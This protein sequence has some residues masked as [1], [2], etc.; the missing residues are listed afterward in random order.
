M[1]KTRLH[2][3]KI[4]N[5]IFTRHIKEKKANKKK[6]KEKKRIRIQGER[7]GVP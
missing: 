3:Y 7:L 5:Q 1:L 2:Y 4:V 6:K